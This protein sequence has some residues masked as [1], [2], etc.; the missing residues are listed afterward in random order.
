MC[1]QTKGGGHVP[2]T[3]TAA[4]HVYKQ[5][6]EFVYL[7]G[8]IS[9]DW[10]LRSVEVTRRIQRACACFGRCKMEIYDRPSGRLRLKVWMLK[11]EVLETLK[12]VSRRVRARL[13]MTGYGRSTSRCSSD[14]SAGGNESAKTTSC[15]MPWRFSGQIPRALRQRQADE[16]YCLRT[17]CH[18]CEKNAC[19]EG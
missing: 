6:V 12:G 9:G 14:A 19:R 13:T 7:G 5:A 8:P 16:G 2:F 4:G 15:P 18:A 17:S 1:L 11:A 10:D 3:V